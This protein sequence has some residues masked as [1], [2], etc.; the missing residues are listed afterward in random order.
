MIK[1]DDL[2][3]YIELREIMDIE[4]ETTEKVNEDEMIF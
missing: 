4:I 2:I 3:N 1:E